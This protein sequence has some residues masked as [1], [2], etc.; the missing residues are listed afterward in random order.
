MAP[1]RAEVAISD[2]VLPAMERQVG[3]LGPGRVE[4]VAQLADLP[5]AQ[6]ADG[7]GQERR[8][9]GAERGGDLR[10][11]GQQE[12]AGQDGDQVAPSGV[13]ALD[14]PAVLGLVHDVVVVQGSEVHQ[15]DGHAP[16]NNVVADVGAVGAANRRRPQPRAQGAAA[17]RRR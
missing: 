15:L 3:G 1:I 2:A 8:H 7:A 9:L 6:L 13:D 11:P 10:R 4:G 12:V 17:S 5:L 16:L 14:A